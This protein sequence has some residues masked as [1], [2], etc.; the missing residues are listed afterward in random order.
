MNAGI[1]NEGALILS[2]GLN[3]LNMLRELNLS[4]NP[5]IAEPG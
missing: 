3:G 2:V 4:W 5:N 1:D